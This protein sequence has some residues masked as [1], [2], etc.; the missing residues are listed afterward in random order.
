ET[1][2]LNISENK[3][4][5]SLLQKLQGF[6]NIALQLANGSIYDQ[7]GKIDMMDG[8]FD[9]STGAVILRA[10]FLNPQG[11]LR[12]GNTGR[13][14]LTDEQPGVFLVPVLA[15]LEMQDKLFVGIVGKDNIVNRV[16]LQ[17]YKKSGD[18][19]IV[20]AGF[21][22]GDRIVANELG[23]IPDKV[24]ITPKPIQ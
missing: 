15:V 6:Q 9:K 21:T 20:K 14:I 3:Q 11:L 4:G 19:Y 18:Y 1:E 16:Q 17:D 5:G 8:Q 24:K 13:I 12:S 22:P 2:I 10:S 23:I 7:T